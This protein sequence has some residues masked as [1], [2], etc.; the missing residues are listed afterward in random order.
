MKVAI[1]DQAT[2]EKLERAAREMLG[3]PNAKT[4]TYCYSIVLDDD[5]EEVKK[6]ACARTWEHVATDGGYLFP[7]VAKLE[8]AAV[9]P[10]ARAKVADAT[11]VTAVDAAIVA[12]KEE[13]KPPV[14]E[15]KPIDDGKEITK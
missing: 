1:V 13:T 7:V 12:A 15:P 9:D 11:A 5:P 10:A 4:K 2:A 3:I 14:E 6:M 8:S